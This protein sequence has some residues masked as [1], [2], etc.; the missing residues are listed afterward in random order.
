[1]RRLSTFPRRQE[2]KLPDRIWQSL[3]V[4]SLETRSA[5]VG[6][7]G[8]YPR[9][10]QDHSGLLGSLATPKPLLEQGRTLRKVI[11]RG[12]PTP[13]CFHSHKEMSDLPCMP[14]APL[15]YW[16]DLQRAIR[17]PHQGYSVSKWLIP[18]IL[19][20]FSDSWH[21]TFK[22][23]SRPLPTSQGRFRATGAG[24]PTR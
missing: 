6:I 19:E 15:V 5:F 24:N 13:T 21:T 22:F 1:M 9:H 4:S 8:R 7:L 12:A 20:P 18:F 2:T 3:K 23:D 14:K 11:P 17:C 10:E 16:L